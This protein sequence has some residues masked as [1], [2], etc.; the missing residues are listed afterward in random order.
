M[1]FQFY[2]FDGII[3]IYTEKSSGDISQDK[4]NIE[5]YNTSHV[6]KKTKTLHS[7]PCKSYF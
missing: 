7:K 4:N 2:L 3:P 1:C 6:S 5:R